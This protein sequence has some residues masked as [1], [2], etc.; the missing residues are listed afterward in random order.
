MTEEQ[1]KRMAER[2]LTWKLP[3]D[4]CPD[5]GV[6]FKR[7]YNEDSPFGLMEHR[8]SGTNLLNFKQAMAMARH[9]VEGLDS[10]TPTFRE[11]AAS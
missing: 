10:S 6:A 11:D 8:P 4:F 1:I 5:G 9:M 2:F 3:E 7:T